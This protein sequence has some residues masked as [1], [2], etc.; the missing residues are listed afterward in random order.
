MIVSA[1]AALVVGAALATAGAT[2]QS[3]LRNPLAEP[4]ML[5]LVGG[6][7]LFTAVAM[8][9][10]LEGAGAFVLPVAAFMGSVFSLSL[11]CGISYV[12]SR[13][14][15]G[16]AFAGETVILAGFVAGSFTGSMY[17]LVMSFAEP[18]TFARLSKWLF[19]DLRSVRP[20]ALSVAAVCAAAAFVAVYSQARALNALSLGE[21]MARTLGV[22]VRRT[23]LVALGAASLATAASVALAGAIGFLGLVVPHVVRRLF[24]A[25]HRAYLPLSALLGALF[26]LVAHEV[27]GRLPKE[28]SAGVVCALCGSPFFLYLLCLR[29]GAECP[30]E[31][32]V[33]A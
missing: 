11:V 14:R 33:N 21:T 29:R 12:A 10:G 22:N 31:G 13:R 15:G 28:L 7:S 32:N 9:F 24:G 19:G 23:R 18:A 4:Y 3:V 8:H 25:N 17:M 6:A 26:L 16:E 20:A 30:R 1:I 27:A 5:G 2:L